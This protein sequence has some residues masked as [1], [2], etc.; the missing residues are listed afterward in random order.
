[1]TF[2]SAIYDLPKRALG[3]HA[4][5]LIFTPKTLEVLY[6]E[7]QL[8]PYQSESGGQLFGEFANDVVTVTTAS[9]PSPKDQRSRYR[10]T[11]SRTTEQAEID[12]EFSNGLHYIGDW[13]T[14]PEFN[15]TPSQ[16]D[17]SGACRLFKT[18]RHQLPNF[19]LVIVG[20]S[21]NLGDL[22]VALVNAHRIKRI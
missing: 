9:T 5:R 19:V 17:R 11:R 3:P 21:S 2:P 7:R 12:H 13:H 4:K 1:M 14:H 22:Y 16:T 20:T 18:S 6:S 8:K 10:F 15:P